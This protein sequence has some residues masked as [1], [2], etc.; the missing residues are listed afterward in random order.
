MT[1]ID[2]GMPSIIIDA[3][4]LDISGHESTKDLESNQELRH[5]IEKLR[6]QC[7]NLMKLGN[8]TEKT[9]PKVTI[10]SQAKFGGI[11]NTRT[12]IPHH[13]HPAIGVFGAISVATACLIRGSSA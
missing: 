12:F 13:C 10:I 8:V 1:M 5:V 7:G 2:N 11:I 4:D 6:L 9:V 3:K